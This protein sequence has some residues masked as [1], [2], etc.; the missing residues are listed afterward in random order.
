[1]LR[2]EMFR[3]ADVAWVLLVNS[4]WF[5]VE[6]GTFEMELTREWGNQQNAFSYGY[7]F[8]TRDGYRFH[9]PV[10]SLVAIVVKR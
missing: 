1:M 8:G 9:G 7:S 2:A 3:N 10:A 5:E 6:S 4:G